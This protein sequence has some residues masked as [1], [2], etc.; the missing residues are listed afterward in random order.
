MEGVSILENSTLAGLKVPTVIK[1][2]LE[3]LNKDGKQDE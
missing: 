1:N 2:V 3:V